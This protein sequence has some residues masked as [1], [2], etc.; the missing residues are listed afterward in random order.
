MRLPRPR[1]DINLPCYNNLMTQPLDERVRVFFNR[2][3]LVGARLVVAV[4]GGPDSVCLLHVL[5][6]LKDG[7]PYPPRG[8][9]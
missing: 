5:S 8:A 6:R 7:L 9:P 1:N 4:S 2:H 3:G